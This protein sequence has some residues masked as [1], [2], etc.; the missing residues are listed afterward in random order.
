MGFWGYDESNEYT[1]LLTRYLIENILNWTDDDIKEKLRK[2]TFRNNSLGGLI[3]IKYNDSAFA[4]ITAAYPE[5]NFHPWDFVNA[6][7][8]YWQREKGRE[9]AIA[10]TKWLIEDKLKW[11][12]HDIIE[13]LNQEVFVKNNLLGML[14]KAFNCSMFEAIDATYSGKFKKWQI[15]DHVKNDYWNKDEGIIAVKWLIEDKLKWNDK[16]IKENYSRQ[17]YRD[18][19]L[20]G[21]IQRCFNS[22]PF[23]AINSTY[24]NRFKEWELPHVP[25][26]FWNSKENCINAAT[27][28][29]EEKLEMDITTAKQ[30]L[31]YKHFNANNILSLYDK[32]PIPKL[33]KMIE[34]GGPTN[35]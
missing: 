6:P 3:C 25:R 33:I 20:Y 4:A 15:G 16:D 17:I 19:N 26:G 10:A 1:P 27:W 21:M 23:E 30:K 32:H 13:N 22:S 2:S 29:I 35:S 34:E 14:K 9:N 11:T 31:S 7:N 28:L 24:P 5:K 8:D 18:N 12:E